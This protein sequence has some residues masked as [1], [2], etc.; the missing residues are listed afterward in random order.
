MLTF[1]VGLFISFGDALELKLL[2]DGNIPYPVSMTSSQKSNE[3]GNFID[4]IHPNLMINNNGKIINNGVTI[5]SGTILMVSNPILI[6][7]KQPSGKKPIINDI[8]M[9]I[10]Y[11]L[12]HPELYHEISTLLGTTNILTNHNLNNIG[13]TILENI[14]GFWGWT[15][16]IQRKTRHTEAN[17]ITGMNPVVSLTVDS[18]RRPQIVW[19]I[20]DIS[21]GDALI[22]DAIT[23]AP[24]MIEFSNYERLMGLY[25]NATNPELK[26][27]V[28]QRILCG[29][30]LFSYFELVKHKGII[31][32]ND[33]GLLNYVFL[34]YMELTD[35]RE[36]LKSL[37]ECCYDMLVKYGKKMIS[38]NVL[39]LGFYR[40]AS[41]TGINKHWD[42]AKLRFWDD[43]KYKFL[44]QMVDAKE[45]TPHKMNNN[46]RVR[47]IDFIVITT[48][49]YDMEA[50]MISKYVEL[51]RSKE[52]YTVF[53]ELGKLHANILDSNTKWA[54]K[55]PKEQ[56]SY[57]VVYSCLISGINI[58]MNDE[59][60]EMLLTHFWNI[61]PEFIEDIVKLAFVSDALDSEYII[62]SNIPDKIFKYGMK[63]HD[64]RCYFMA[65]ML[66]HINIKSIITE[67]SLVITNLI[68]GGT[69]QE[70]NALLY[71]ALEYYEKQNFPY[72][73]HLFMELFNKAKANDDYMLIRRDGVIMKYVT[74]CWMVSDMDCI[75]N[76]KSFKDIIDAGAIFKRNGDT[77]YSDG[78]YGVAVECYALSMYIEYNTLDIKFDFSKGVHELLIEMGIL[79]IQNNNIDVGYEYLDKALELYPTNCDSYFI[80]MET[81]SNIAMYQ[82]AIEIFDRF[83]GMENMRDICD[84]KTRIIMD[85]L[86]VINYKHLSNEQMCRY[87]EE[88]IIQLKRM[89]VTKNPT[90]SPTTIGPTISPTY[91]PT[92]NPTK[93]PTNT[94]SST[95]T[96]SPSIMPTNIPTNSPS[97]KPS[98]S[99]F[100]APTNSPTGNPTYIPTPSPIV[101]MGIVSNNANVQILFDSMYKRF[102]VELVPD[103]YID[104]PTFRISIL[105][106]NKIKR[107]YKFFSEIKDWLKW[108]SKKISAGHNE[109]KKELKNY[110]N[111]MENDIDVIDHQSI[112]VILYITYNICNRYDDM[113]Y[114]F[115]AFLETKKLYH[116]TDAKT[117]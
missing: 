42:D 3:Y 61:K 110:Y 102:N 72:A 6:E 92:M 23:F 46:I 68:V 88:E 8:K 76:M 90:E 115:A 117:R 66:G 41:I 45:I 81:V 83:N 113:A 99:P 14:K 54:D 5:E 104:N 105:I 58:R 39:P 9:Q 67:M 71:L 95:P 108:Q 112:H 13:T 18:I 51:M 64:M 87:Y 34:S 26:T 60:M 57:E 44:Y 53:I 38:H 98:N 47:A 73:Y 114:E 89:L 116:D 28:K 37:A 48:R 84:I 103:T 16:L 106:G 100:S 29:Q 35:D 75:R 27:R 82:K 50:D 63:R 96:N 31:Y 20:K 91:N 80:Y 22:T 49:L 7:N 25:Y 30:P 12:E 2:Y 74:A 1:F 52:Y 11:I 33:A 94:P 17:V 4:F 21:T 43:E 59:V 79:S 77:L 86:A 65:F 109:L 56:I 97:N 69:S 19:A 85:E 10:N 15:H 55:S 40:I 101:S 32:E 62:T 93:K 24:M 111:E 36:Y 70:N 78:H 107:Y